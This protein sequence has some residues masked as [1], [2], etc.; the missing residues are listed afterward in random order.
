MPNKLYLV[1][2]VVQDKEIRHY[3]FGKCKKIQLGILEF[4]G[5]LFLSCREDD[6][7]YCEKYKDF[8][9]VTID[10][11]EL[12]VTVRKLKGVDDDNNTT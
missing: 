1:S 12:G 7:L 8:G 3:C 2:P 6:C 5:G 9:N 11:E 10:K 4:L